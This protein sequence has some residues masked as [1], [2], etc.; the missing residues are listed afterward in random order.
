MHPMGQDILSLSVLTNTCI[1]THSQRTII[2]GITP[3]LHIATHTLCL[4]A[5]HYVTHAYDPGQSNICSQTCAFPFCA[6]AAT[7]CN[8]VCTLSHFYCAHCHARI[9][10]NDVS[11]VLRLVCGSRVLSAYTIYVIRDNGKLGKSKL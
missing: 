6:K 3:P 9:I 1:H 5:L 8:D 2:N 10:F 11:N 7:A 4:I